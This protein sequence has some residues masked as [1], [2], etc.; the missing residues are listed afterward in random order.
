M[1]TKRQTIIP[2]SVAARMLTNAG[3]ERV[4]VEAA[5]EFALVLEEIGRSISEYA[6]RLAEHA[7]RKTVL[8]EDVKFAAK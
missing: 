6:V 4:S 8:G 5:H 3:A 7:K 2:L 1:G